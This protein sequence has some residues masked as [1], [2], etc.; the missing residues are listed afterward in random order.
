[1]NAPV[2]ASATGTSP[3]RSISFYINGVLAQK[4]INSVPNGNSWG[5]GTAVQLPKQGV[6]YTVKAS[7]T[8]SS[9]HTYSSTKSVTGKYTYSTYGCAPKDTQCFPGT[10]L[11]EE[12]CSV[13]K[14]RDGTG[15]TF[16]LDILFH[17]MSGV[18]CSS[19]SPAIFC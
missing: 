5:V 9:G 12:N 13:R 10:A 17:R 14:T 1:V 2:D 15:E 11:C 3:I 19:K 16:L 6:A 7:A 4:V 8:D 18:A